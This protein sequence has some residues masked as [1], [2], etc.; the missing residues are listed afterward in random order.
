M[1]MIKAGRHQVVYNDPEHLREIL[2]QYERG[3]L[4]Y[5]ER[6]FYGRHWYEI[7]PPKGFR[8]LSRRITVS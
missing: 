6:E 4:R 8:R 3:R 1:R 7:T 5:F 2:E